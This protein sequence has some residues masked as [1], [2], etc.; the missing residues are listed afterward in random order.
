MMTHL[1]ILNIT[2]WAGY[3][4]SAEHLYG[5]LILSERPDV[6]IENVH[7]W[8]V[9]YLGQ[10]IKIQR[11]LT[12]ELARRLD[13]KDGH[14]SNTRALRYAAENPEMGYT[15]RFDNFDQVVDAGIEKW[16]EL[17][18]NCPFISL[19]E[20]SRYEANHH[21]KYST[22]VVE[23]LQQKVEDLKDQQVIQALLKTDTS[24]L[25]KEEAFLKLVNVIDEIDEQ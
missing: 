20:G 12:E 8:S 1:A 3:D 6:T 2:S 4:T 7:E 16:K 17:G 22:V 23:P 14:N 10:E 18:L 21:N 13:K 19:Y 24:G 11:K 5:T 9:R 15:E 25:S